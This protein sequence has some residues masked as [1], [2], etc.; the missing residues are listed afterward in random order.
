VFVKLIHGE[1]SA[2]GDEI[3]YEVLYNY[4]NGFEDFVETFEQ[5]LQEQEGLFEGR[6]E[7]FFEALQGGGPWWS[8]IIDSIASAAG[9]LKAFVDWYTAAA[10]NNLTTLLGNPLRRQRGRIERQVFAKSTKPAKVICAVPR[11][12]GESMVARLWRVKS[13]LPPQDCVFE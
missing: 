9:T 12:H 6:F 2:Q 10:I 8:K 11:T 3:K 1:K 5:R 4:S 7:L 13:Q